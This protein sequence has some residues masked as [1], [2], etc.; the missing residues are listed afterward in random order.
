MILLLPSAE[1]VGTVALSRA[2]R[3]D[4]QHTAHRRLV[5]G[6]LC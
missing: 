3:C 6:Y 5:C 1:D 4:L 2:S